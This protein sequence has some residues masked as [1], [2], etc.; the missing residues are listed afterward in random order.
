MAQDHI[1]TAC[2]NARLLLSR[3]I[4]QSTQSFNHST[5]E[6]TTFNHLSILSTTIIMLPFSIGSLRKLPQ[7]GQSSSGSG[8]RQ[9]DSFYYSSGSQQDPSGISWAGSGNN[10][11]YEKDNYGFGRYGEV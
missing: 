9:Q 7:G 4:S 8:G 3:T 6:L 2:F 5:I 11:P 1:R 10:Q